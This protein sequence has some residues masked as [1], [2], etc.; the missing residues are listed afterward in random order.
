ML[1]GPPGRALG[2]IDSRLAATLSDSRN[3]AAARDLA[4]VPI[5]GVP[6]WHRDNEREAFYEDRDYFRPGRIRE[7][8][9][10]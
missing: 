1:A 6:G 5:L 7:M 8:R 4:V 3:L 9:D 10:K 2:E